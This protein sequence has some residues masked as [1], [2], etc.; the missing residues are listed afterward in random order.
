ML[1][2]GQK[3]LE[4]KPKACQNDMLKHDACQAISW[5]CTTSAWS[6]QRL[7]KPNPNRGMTWQGITKNMLKWKENK[8]E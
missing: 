1:K 7:T 4:V 3:L 8:L 5:K 2:H 6:M